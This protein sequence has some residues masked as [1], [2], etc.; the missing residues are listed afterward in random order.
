M[1]SHLR[2][3]ID[4]LFDICK[5]SRHGKFCIFTLDKLRNM[6]YN[7]GRDRK[8][9]P[10]NVNKGAESMD[11]Q[12]GDRERDVFNVALERFNMSQKAAASLFNVSRVTIYNWSLGKCEIPKRVFIALLEIE[13]RNFLALKERQ[14]A[15]TETV[16]RLKS[17]LFDPLATISSTKR[18]RGRPPKKA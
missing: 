15:I 8:P 7:M 9:G 5:M 4:F 13:N 2:L 12:T 18:R 3:K 6:M 14:A 1:L 17:G 16:E 10:D 11:K